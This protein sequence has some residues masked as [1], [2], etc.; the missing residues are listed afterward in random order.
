[1]IGDY[2]QVLTGEWRIAIQE[3][4]LSIIQRD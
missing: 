2:P 3:T 1:V 4:N